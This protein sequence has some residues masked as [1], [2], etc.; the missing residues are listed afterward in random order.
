VNALDQDRW[1]ALWRA[2][3]ASG[4]PLPWFSRLATAYSEPHRHYHNQRHIGECLAEF[5]GARH[6]ARHGET[7]ELA[8]WFHDAVYD[9]KAADNEEQSAALA[10]RCLIEAGVQAA[11]IAA[12]DGLI[13]AT[14]HHEVGT[15][16]DT[17]LMVD[18]DLSIFGQPE[19]RFLEYE[20]QIREEYAWV[21]RI[22]FGPKRAKI[23]ERFLG[24]KRLYAS[25]WFHDKYERQARRNLEVSIRNLRRFFA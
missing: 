18:V 25:D 5:D 23:L 21:P 8:L 10:E 6:L 3:I 14:K 7:I 1:V 9:P 24:R 16:E 13:M 12:V 17:A 11:I 19:E 2:I 22:I 15:D 4:D 20:A